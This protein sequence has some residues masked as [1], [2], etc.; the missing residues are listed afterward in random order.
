MVRIYGN[1]D[2]TTLSYI[3]SAPPGCPTTISAGQVVECG[4]VNE[5]F[6]VKGTTRSPSASSRRAPRVVDPATQPPNQQG[7]PDESFAIAVE[8]YRTKYVFLAPDRLH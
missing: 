7:D 3:P 2:G 5:D 4:V 1:F 6:E 8:Q